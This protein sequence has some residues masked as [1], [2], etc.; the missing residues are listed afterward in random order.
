MNNTSLPHILII[1]DVFGRSHPDKRNED[2]ANLCRKYLF[3]DVTGDE[4]DKENTLK[5]KKPVAEVVFYRGVKPDCS[6]LGDFVEHDIE[7]SIEAIKK[8]WINEN[9]GFQPWSLVLLD[10]CFYTGKVTHQSMK[11]KGEGMPEGRNSDNDPSNYFGLKILEVIHDKFP[12]LPVIVFSSKPRDEIAREFSRRG[13]LGF[14]PR[15]GENSPQLLQEYIDRHGLIPDY[16]GE[17][18]G[19]SKALLIAL[20]SARRA[21]EKQGNILLR[22]ETGTGK[23]LFA[24]YIHNSR[25][26][27]SVFPFVIVNTP[28]L[29]SSL[30][31]SE[32]FGINRRAATGVDERLGKIRAADTGDLFFDEIGDML[33]ETQAGILRVLEYKEVTPVGSET[34]YPVNVRFLSATN[35][36]IEAKSAV[37]SFRSDLLYR[38]N[39]GGT[40]ILPPLRE[41][42]ADIRLL[43]EKFVHKAENN[44]SSALKRQIETEAIEKILAFEWEGNIR[45]LESVVTTAV[46]NNPDVEY[47]VPNHLVLP[48]KVKEKIVPS[49]IDKTSGIVSTSIITTASSKNKNLEELIE[50]IENCGFDPAQPSE[51]KGKLP[52]LQKAFAKLIASYLKTTL[53]ATKKITSENPNGETKYTSAVKLMTGNQ[54]L[55]SSTAADIV[56]RLLSSN[57]ESTETI[58]EDEVLKEVYEKA[59]TLRPKNPKKVKTD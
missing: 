14:L 16:S 17:I 18:I 36:D 56:K 39:Q 13:A 59:R 4:S 33:L 48:S 45:Q 49:E 30:W 42:L 52:I 10:M 38:L 26:K 7:G 41:R 2:R 22:G 8:G 29:T 34:S 6:K 19:N 5:I 31:E 57:P 25:R 20:R 12:D 46:N 28:A 35:I 58:L 47:L 43:V 44:N 53:L 54:N 9:S 40:V 32:L 51:L 27:N 50:A 23:E 55:T 21:A 3:K 15:E 1:D 11:S 24:R 37:G